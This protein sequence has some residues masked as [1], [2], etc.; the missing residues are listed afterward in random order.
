MEIRTLSSKKLQL[1]ELNL[2]TISGR[3]IYIRKSNVLTQDEFAQKLNTSKGNI[4]SWETGAYQPSFDK[5]VLISELF[6]VNS[7]WLLHGRGQMLSDEKDDGTKKPDPAHDMPD[8]ILESQN[9][10]LKRA[11]M[12]NLEA[13][14]GMVKTEERLEHLEKQ[15]AELTAM[16][17]QQSRMA[18]DRRQIA[19]TSPDG[20]ERR[21]GKDRRVH[22][23]ASDGDHV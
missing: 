5:L 16:V 18:T 9:P 4:S 6:P 7:D 15:V 3:I 13:F 14:S 8:V 17:Q 2:L 21:L 10:V 23:D 22:Y 1:S 11:I 20:I 19:S 12:A